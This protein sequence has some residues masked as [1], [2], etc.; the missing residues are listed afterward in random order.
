MR[1]SA[2]LFLLLFFTSLTS[3]RYVTG[4]RVRG[5]GQLGTVVRPVGNFTG[6]HAKGGIDVVVS[7]GPSSTLK[8]EAD[9]NLID[10]IEVHNNNGIVEVYT[11][12]GYNLRPQAGIRVL[13]MAPQFSSIQISGS[14]NISSPNKILGSNKLHVEIR[15][16]G[17]INLNVDA[18][19][20]E[21]E[22][23]GSGSAT[24]HGNTQHFVADINGS[25]DV[26]AMNL[27]S[28]QTT[29]DI[30]GSGNADVFA[31]KVLNVEIKG[32]GNVAYKGP[33]TVNQ[34]IVGSG[35]VQKVN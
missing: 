20:V 27:M 29:V 31:S 13:A 5:N 3:C 10:Y 1:S 14:G 30:S 26:R 24:M 18:P 28:E 19:S 6:V 32:A 16:S 17:D 25:G 9:Q 12:D 7:N 11:K 35:S 15:G 8:I 34:R 23:S 4:K 21:T 33:A 22:I 2:L